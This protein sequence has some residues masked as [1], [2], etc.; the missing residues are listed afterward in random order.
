VFCRPRFW[1]SILFVVVCVVVCVKDRSCV[2]VDDKLR[3]GWTL[4][5]FLDCGLEGVVV[6][7]LVGLYVVG[8]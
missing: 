2:L 7:W 1:L 4:W 5:I 3:V 8:Q 6:Q